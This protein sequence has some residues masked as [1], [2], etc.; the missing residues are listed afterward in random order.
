MNHKHE[1]HRHREGVGMQQMSTHL[2]TYST[3][4]MV[5]Q[6][7]GSVLNEQE[8]SHAL[9]EM[10]TNSSAQ[11]LPERDNRYECEDQNMP[12]GT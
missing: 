6:G 5:K 2:E 10:H 3:V 9:N 4:Q 12:L 1:R 11:T 7:N 8:M